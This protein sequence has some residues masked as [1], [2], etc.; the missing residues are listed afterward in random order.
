ML[1]YLDTLIGFAVVMLI[2]SLL[3]TILTQC[4]SAL[5]SHRGS[6]LRW[7]LKTLFENIDPV[8]YPQLTANSETVANEVLRHCLVSDSVFS[9]NGLAIWL[10][11]KV[12]VLQKLL[13]RF[14]LATAIRPDELVDILRQTSAILPRSLAAL[15]AAAQTQLQTEIAALLA[16]SNK[17]SAMAGNLEVWFGSIMDRVAQRFVMYMRGWTVLFGCLFAF[18]SGLNSV[19]LLNELYSNGAIRSALVGSGQQVAASAATVLN[20]QNTMSAALTAALKQALG[21]AN[22]TTAPQP[23]AIQT[24]ADGI[25]WIQANVPAEQRAAVVDRFNTDSTAAAQ[26]I[27]QDGAQSAAKVIDI[28]SKSDFDVAKFRWPAKPNL[29][30]FLGVAATA[31]LLSLGAPFWFNALKSMTNLRPILASKED[32]PQS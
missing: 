4:V 28:A 25:A 2:L 9:D 32:A 19:S 5:C 18:G 7:G 13:E 23:P 1:L 12:P 20:P 22:V 31:A 29:G 14:Q 11:R 24:T 21:D 16:A 6:N 17:A 26:K 15:P 3:I 27:I 10:A 30:Y 8:L